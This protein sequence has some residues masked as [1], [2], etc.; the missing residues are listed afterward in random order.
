MNRQFLV[1]T[2]FFLLFYSLPDPSSAQTKRG[3]TPEDY[4][5]F[6]FIGD[7]H[8]APDGRSVA[9]VQTII[10][11]KKNKRESSIW[12]IAAD[13]SGTARR[14]TAEG[15]NANAPRWSPDGQTLAFLS[16]R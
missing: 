13:G 5:A 10:D 15:S 4:F 9:Y 1:S 8:L 12:V 2:L 14:L 16:S 3:I 11:Q 7:P 6:Q